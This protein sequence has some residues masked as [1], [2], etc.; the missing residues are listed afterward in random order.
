MLC[1]VDEFIREALAVR[2]AR[3]LTSANVIDTLADL[4]IRHGVSA[5]TRSDQGAEFI[6]EPEKGWIS[7]VEFSA[8]DIERGGPWENGYAEASIHGCGTSC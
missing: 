8:V 2:V 4:F 7:G 1:A 6:A 3:K 5:R